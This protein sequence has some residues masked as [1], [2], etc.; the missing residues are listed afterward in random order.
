MGFSKVEDTHFPKNNYL[1]VK[2]NL[3]DLSVPKIMGIVNL[4]PDSFYSASRNTSYKAL[5]NTIN[6]MIIDGA[7]LIDIGGYSTKPGADFV[8][9]DEELKRILEPISLIKKEFPN[10]LLTLDTFRANVVK[11][12]I[13]LG[14]DIIN[15]ISGFNYDP[16]LLDVI[17]ETKT[18]YILMHV[19]PQFDQMHQTAANENLF[20]DMIYYFSDKLLQLKNRGIVD[21]IIDPGFGFGKTLEQNYS[22]LKNLELFHILERPILVGLSRKSM[23]HKKLKVSVEGS[24]NGTTILNTQA[25]LK[26]VSILRVHDVKEAKQIIELIS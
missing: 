19:N 15:D 13:D 6:Q 3:I 5:L 23:I 2:D 14:V 18:P 21:V 22:I 26:G 17:S 16:N 10:I 8:S 25:I 12:G 20:R 9:E 4:T 11:R 24:L 7:D 1:R